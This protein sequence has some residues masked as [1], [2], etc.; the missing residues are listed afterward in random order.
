MIQKEIGNYHTRKHGRVQDRIVASSN[1]LPSRMYENDFIENFHF[2]RC[3]KAR[4]VPIQQS[5]AR[6]INVPRLYI[7]VQLYSSNMKYWD[8]V[9]ADTVTFRYIFE[10]EEIMAKI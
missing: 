6:L 10:N 9:I 4:T 5:P 7:S 2:K 3:F 1:A 8:F